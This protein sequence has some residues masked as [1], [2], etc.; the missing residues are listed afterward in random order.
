MFL[1]NL[2]EIFR[3][4]LSYTALGVDKDENGLSNFLG[5]SGA[6]LPQQFQIW[7]SL[8][9]YVPYRF[10]ASMTSRDIQAKGPNVFPHIAA[11]FPRYKKLTLLT[12]TGIFGSQ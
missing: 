8:G 4:S 12:A 1:M 3:T 7:T 6:G 10:W 11:H 5:G 9:N 2:G